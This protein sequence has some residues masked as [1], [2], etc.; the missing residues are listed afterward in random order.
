MYNQY[1][2]RYFALFKSLNAEKFCYKFLSTISWTQDTSIF[3]G[4][5]KMKFRKKI[6]N[7]STKYTYLNFFIKVTKIS[8]RIRKNL[9]TNLF[10]KNSQKYHSFHLKFTNFH[11]WRDWRLRWKTTNATIK[12]PLSSRVT[13]RLNFSKKILT[14]RP[15]NIHY[16]RQTQH[17]DFS[18]SKF[19][20]IHTKLLFS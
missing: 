4:I 8:Q 19:I 7:E 15:L 20:V 14:L 18:F 12:H 3:G 9:K 16:H 10:R 2:T 17:S 11:T 1:S 13:E 6:L 5:T